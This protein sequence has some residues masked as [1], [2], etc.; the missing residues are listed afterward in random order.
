[1]PHD[2]I[3][4]Q[5]MLAC[6]S[7]PINKIDVRI[8]GT[9]AAGKSWD[10]SDFPTQNITTFTIGFGNGLSESGWPLLRGGAMQ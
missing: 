9:D 1:A 8:D 4:G 2:P 6:F 7:E 5:A 10:D 3:R